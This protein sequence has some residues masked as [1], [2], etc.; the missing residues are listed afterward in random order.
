VCLAAA[1]R[2]VDRRTRESRIDWLSQRLEAFR[3]GAER[4]ARPV[5]FSVPPRIGGE[6]K[7]CLRARE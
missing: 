3:A 2:V 5:F 6:P 7:A 1:A 4:A